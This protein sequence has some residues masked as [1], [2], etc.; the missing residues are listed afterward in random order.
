MTLTRKWSFLTAVLVVAV[1]AAGW[2]LLVSP[3]RSEAADLQQQASGQASENE[4]LVQ[5]L[6]VLKAQQAD[7]PRQRAR[8]ATL[9]TQLPDNPALPRLVRDLTAAGRKTGVQLASLAPAVPVQL[10]ATVQ[11][12]PV[13]APPAAGTEGTTEGTAD[14]AAAGTTD[15][16]TEGS[17]ATAPA[18]PANVLYQVPLVIEATGSYFELEQ[19]VN[20]LESLKRSLLVSGFTLG[21]LKESGSG[22]PNVVAAPTND[23]TLTLQSRV[24][25]SAPA[26][27]VAQPT[28]VA[29]A[30]AGE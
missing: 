30:S 22:D 4:R 15:T 9:Q 19:F 28:P 23:L 16:A 26:P 24:F 25:I 29:S 7:L 13:A 21:E 20:K 6:E 27:A 18:A 12:T 5:K 8:L 14:G 10:V 2:F 11:G 1:L 17:A 3:K